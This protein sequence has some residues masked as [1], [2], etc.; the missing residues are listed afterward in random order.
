MK[1]FTFRFLQGKTR[2]AFFSLFLM[3][4]LSTQATWSQQVIGQFPTLDGGFEAQASSGAIS[5]STFA[6]GVQSAVWTTNSANMG[7]FQT[8][9][10]RTG[11]KYVNL[12][13]TSTTKRFQ[14]PT[15]P[16]DA[17][18]GG[19][20]YTVQYYYRTASTVDP[21]GTGQK[22]GASSDGTSLTNMTY[23]SITPL[24]PATSGLWSKVQFSVT[25][26]TS[27]AT[28]PKYGYVCAFRTDV[29]MGAAMDVDDF[30]FYAG[31]ADNTVPADATAASTSPASLISLNVN[32]TGLLNAGDGGGYV[33]VRST[34]ANAVTLNPNGIY[35]V[36]NTSAT[37]GGTIVAIV[38]GV[39]GAN[40]YLDSGLT[41]GTTYY[42]S[43]FAVDKAFN[44]SNAAT[45]SGTPSSTTP[46][47]LTSPASLAFS[48]VKVNTSNTQSFNLYGGTLSPAS[49]NITVTAP[50]GFLVSTSSTTGF[51]S[52]VNVPYT[53]G[54]LGSTTIYVKFSPTA[55][56]AYPGSISLSGG[57]ATLSVSLTANGSA[58]NLGSYKSVATGNWSATTTWSK[59]DGLT[60]NACVSPDFPNSSTSDVYV[61]GGFTVTYDPAVAAT[62]VNTI[63]AAKSCSN[64]YVD[65]NSTLNS[66]G[67]VNAVK[68]LN[69]YG[70]TVSV[71]SG[72]LLGNTATGNSTDGISLN[73]LSNNLI[74]TGGGTINIARIINNIA[75]T[76]LV[77]DT[78]VT[79]NYHGTG[80]AGHATGYYIVSGD[81]NILTVNTGKTLTFAP[82]SCLLY[83][84]GGH[85]TASNFSQTINLY[86]TMTF[87][88]GD[89]G[90]TLSATVA[91]AWAGH[92]NY[93]TMNVNGTASS[94]LNVY[95]GGVLNVSEFYPNGTAALNTPGVGNVVGIN[96]ATGGK[97]NVSKI[98]DFRNVAQTV[99]GGGEFNL[100][101]GATLKIGATTGIT[102][103]AAAGPIQTTT[104]G[105]NVGANYSYEGTASQVTGNGLPSNVNGLTIGNTTGVTLTSSATVNGGLTFTAGNLIT[106]SNL[107]T[108]GTAATV[109]GAGSTA[110]IVGSVSKQ[111]SSNASPTF[112]YPIGDA[113][114]YAPIALTFNG[115]N[116]ATTTG[117][118]TASTTSG[119]HP[120]VASSG[121]DNANSVNRFWTLSNNGVT[122]FTD[123]SATLNYAA[124]D[125]D[126]SSLPANYVVR[127]YSASTWSAPLT[128]ATPS[129][130]TATVTGLLNFGDLAIG[131]PT[132]APS[133]S[134][135]PLASSICVGSNATF[136]ASAATSTVPT[137]IKWQ[138]STD[139]TAWSDVTANLDAGTTYSNFTTGTLTLTGSASGLN[140]YQYRAV[141]T[142]I[143][144]STNSN[145]VA[146]TV[147]TTAAPTASAQSFCNSGTVAGLTAT[148]TGLQWYSA[149]TGGTA[150][151]STTALASGNYFVS[152]TLNSCEGPRASVAVTV[153]TTAAPTASAQSFCNTGTVA[154]LTATGTGLQWYSAATGGTALASTT[155]LASGNYFVS[156]TLNSCEGP[157][158]SVA[159]TV[160]TTAAPTAS[161]QSF[162][163][164][165]T[166]AGLT[167]TGTG[168]QWYS[169][170]TGGTALASTTALASGNYFVSQTLNSCE[171]P[172]TS[173]AV[174]V[175]TTAA[176]TAS[177]QSFC[178]SGTVAGLTATGTGLQWYSTST[179]G[180]PLASTTA[181]ATGTYFV[182]QTVNSC[183]GPRTSV[184]VTVNTTAAPTGAA[185]QSL[186]SLLT[187]SSIVVTGTNVVWYAS[188]ANAA[189]GTNPLPSTT[190]LTNTTYYATQTV[191]GCTSATSLAVTITTLSNQ[192][193]DM[194]QF[195][196]YPNP[197]NDVLNL[198]YYQDMNSVKVYNM[199]GQELMTKQVNANTAQIDLSNFV[200][201]AYFIQVTTGSAM[202]TVRIIKR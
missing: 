7:T 131:T 122:G 37:G 28:T 155:A 58:Y 49:G 144:G 130:T 166:V 181:L 132:A 152:Q 77:I 53:G 1:N 94:T 40:T 201:G 161:A 162:C 137:T 111:T 42:Y 96:V 142:S 165:G 27:T 133:V 74:I 24:L 97:I 73:V 75:N 177:A 124:A 8:A 141:F 25:A 11:T 32:W 153:N 175:N 167:A 85:S 101:A 168:L 129:N 12:N 102:A 18:V 192:D 200:N 125:N 31:A 20:A 159:V 63:A 61:T 117:S 19:T 2:F 57:S 189:S 190:P 59:W 148:G 99:T 121:L 198:S 62:V 143:N 84:S 126:V 103:S 157:R 176:P 10:P 54:S 86:G 43:I 66:T 172:R 38:P 174:T 104:R 149:A 69:V 145:A 169:A 109:T 108:L 9:S 80:N 180:T 146:L 150:L 199:I 79:L 71:G 116:T 95:N 135:Q 156:Q 60:W 15:A 183:Q 179:S 184:A 72:S 17:I 147:N 30:V 82:W 44:Y 23:S 92:N 14:S 187:I 178:N 138:R 56:Q 123:Y 110:W 194:S 115:N 67:L 98:A 89:L 36:N 68:W 163:N 70:N 197:V 185:S 118:I 16:Q 171:G 120:Q 105:F 151:A 136:T 47:L 29:A 113:T 191:G 106:G 35:A 128:S 193:F 154:G 81:N 188:S 87:V 21:G 55:I 160:N 45:C 91:N 90:G 51:A 46:A 52:T 182:S 76:N 139:G 196:Y 170:A 4:L 65:T 186:S 107:L 13:F 127:R 41:P 33:I 173:V 83:T 100:L 64:L 140:N 48:Y 158:A 112:T 93:F 195:S 119:D 5:S 78:D 26:V 6:T 34:S 164:S 88:D 3:L 50:T 114:T 134:L 202:K 22:V 39:A